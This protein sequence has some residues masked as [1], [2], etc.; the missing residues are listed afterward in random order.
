LRLKK[1]LGRKKKHAKHAV[2]EMSALLG[3]V[4]DYNQVT[5][6]EHVCQNHYSLPWGSALI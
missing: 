1:N 2:K 4:I 3:K 5:A 6:L